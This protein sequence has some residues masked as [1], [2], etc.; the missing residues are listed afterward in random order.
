MVGALAGW[1]HWRGWLSAAGMGSGGASKGARPQT[2]SD[3]S[4]ADSGGS[5]AECNGDGRRHEQA[6]GGLP[7]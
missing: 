7:S 1:R 5:D 2:T 6:L 3:M 4:R